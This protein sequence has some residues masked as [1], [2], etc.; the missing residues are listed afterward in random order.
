MVFVVQWLPRRMMLGTLLP[1][2]DLS[3][4]SCVYTHTT[5]G[6]AWTSRDSGSWQMEVAA[7]WNAMW[8]DHQDYATWLWWQGRYEE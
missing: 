6:E 1:P 5:E 3:A 2:Y 7:G 8:V 4:S